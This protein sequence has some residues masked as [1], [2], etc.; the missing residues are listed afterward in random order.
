MLL[1]NVCTVALLYQYC[2]R[3]KIKSS[4]LFGRGA[5]T[6]LQDILAILSWFVPVR[7]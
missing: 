7:D 5:F 4:F 3:G 6:I 1:D 2:V